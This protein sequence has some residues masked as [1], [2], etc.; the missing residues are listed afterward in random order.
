MTNRC[1]NLHVS[2]IEI[3]LIYFFIN[4]YKLHIHLK[5]IKVFILQ[6]TRPNKVSRF[7]IWTQTKSSKGTGGFM[8]LCKPGVPISQFLL[9]VN[10]CPKCK[11]VSRRFQPGATWVKY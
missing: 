3:F 4:N 6:M 2:L 1:D 10:A 7:K 11:S 8:N 9:W 5:N